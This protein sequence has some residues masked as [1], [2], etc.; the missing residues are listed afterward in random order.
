MCAVCCVWRLTALLCFIF[1]MIEFNSLL[2]YVISQLSNLWNRQTLLKAVPDILDKNVA[3]Y[4]QRHIF[5]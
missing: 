1:L 2:S 5:T 4:F 3:R